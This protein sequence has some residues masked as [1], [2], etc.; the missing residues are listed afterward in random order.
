MY[1]IL[2]LKYC[3]WMC[4]TAAIWGYAASVLAWT[5]SGSSILGFKKY[6]CILSCL[7][8]WSAAQVRNVRTTASLDL[9]RTVDHCNSNQYVRLSAPRTAKGHDLAVAGEDPTELGAGC[10]AGHKRT[11][12][13]SRCPTN[14]RHFRM[15]F[16]SRPL[17]PG[18]IK[19]RRPWGRGGLLS[20][21]WRLSDLTL[22]ANH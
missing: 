5:M 18:E 14:Y 7:Q 19:K 9:G 17:L 15:S 8:R 4:D 2:N 1:L 6:V 12:C 11:T 22:S 21:A 16:T 13:E 3:S 20:V 10:L